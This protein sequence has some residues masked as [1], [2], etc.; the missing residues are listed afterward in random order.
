MMKDTL[1]YNGNILTMDEEIYAESLLIRNGKVFAYG[2]YKKIYKLADDDALLV[3][4]K[5]NTLMSSNIDYDLA[6]LPL[7]NSPADL[8]ILNL[9]PMKSTIEEIKEMKVL[10]IIENGITTYK[11]EI[12]N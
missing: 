5:G 11:L 4:L 3:D 12:Q 10:E 8:V 9:N 1:F 7:I 6:S 2:D